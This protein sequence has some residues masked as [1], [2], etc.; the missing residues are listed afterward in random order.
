MS[1]GIRIGF[2]WSPAVD[3]STRCGLRRMVSIVTAWLGVTVLR[4]SVVMRMRRWWCGGAA[5]SRRVLFTCPSCK[6]EAVLPVLDGPSIT[7]TTCKRRIPVNRVGVPILPDPQ[8]PA[9][10]RVR[11]LEVDPIP[12]PSRRVRD[13]QAGFQKVAYEGK[14]RICRKP[15]VHGMPGVEGSWWGLTRHHLVPRSQGGD[16]ID[17]NLVP[18]CGDGVSG[19]HGDVEAYRPGARHSLRIALTRQEVEYVTAKKGRAWLD[20]AYP[21]V[22]ARQAG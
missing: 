22:S 3:S 8:T 20:N 17:D 19:C 6:A 5:V 13:S 2:A 10:R 9:K 15:A 21:D 14:C 12:R 16:D 4:R 11:R 7:C 18:L 1:I